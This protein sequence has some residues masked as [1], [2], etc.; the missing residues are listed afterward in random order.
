MHPC[1][2]RTAAKRRQILDAAREAFATHG[3]H[4]ASMACIAGGAGV[5]VGHIYRYF[6]NKEAVIGAIVDADL[7]EAAVEIGAL[8]GDAEALA[9]HI[10]EHVRRHN[11]PAKTS[12]M[13][14]ILAEASR[15]PRIA[16]RAQAADAQLRHHL[17]QALVRRSRSSEG[18]EARVEVICVLIEG[19]MIRTL[20][21]ADGER[22]AVAE[23]VRRLLVQAITA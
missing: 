3:F 14:E 16:A 19:L 18:I 17:A 8:E 2:P 10:V 6:E 4:A 13:L 22:D 15:N 12:L 5:S 7:E 9:A 20:K 23:D 21:M 11:G 1:A